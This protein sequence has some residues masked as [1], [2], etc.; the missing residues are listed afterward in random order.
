VCD[1]GVGSDDPGCLN[2][3]TEIEEFYKCGTPGDEC[4]IRCGDG[5]ID[6]EDTWNA[7]NETCDDG[8]TDSGDGCQDDC[9]LIEPGYE[10][11]TNGTACNLICG[12]GDLEATGYTPSDTQDQTY[13]GEA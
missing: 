8:N 5:I 12:N 1:E 2:C 10:C 6:D 13:A 11:P 4:T 9:D 7:F 3:C